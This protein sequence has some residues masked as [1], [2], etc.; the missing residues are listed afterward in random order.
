[1]DVAPHPHIGLQTVTW[2]F[3]GEIVHNDSLD[4]ECLVRPGQLSLMTAGSGIA[5]TEE[6]P[7]THSGQLDGVQFWVALPS[8]HR[9]QR[10]H[11]LC[12][13]DQPRQEHSGALVTTILGAYG[14]TQSPGSVYSPAL[15]LEIKVH[16]G[17]R[18]ELPLLPD[19]EYGLLL[20]QGQASSCGQ[21]LRPNT[22]YYLGAGRT[23]LPLASS[24]GATLLLI[25]GLPFPESILMWWNF[26]AR[27]PEEIL[28]AR[29]AWEQNEVFGPVPRY[30]GPRLAAPAYLGRPLPRAD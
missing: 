14:G 26:V 30:Q 19:F 10:P 12:T 23:E 5:H 4:N 29:Q 24:P 20:A 2:L 22:L 21:A 17:S 18:A 1:M 3:S 13:R 16:P 9:H 11:Y 28:A 7:G 27:T 8:E 15:G 6:T 25:G